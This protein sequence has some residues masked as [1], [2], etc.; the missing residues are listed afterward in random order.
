M[1]STR[2]LSQL[3]ASAERRAVILHLF[4]VPP[5]PDAEEH[6]TAGG[7]SSDATSL[8]VVMGS[9]SGSGHTQMPEATL[10]VVVTA[11]AIDNDTKRS[12]VCMYSFGSTGPPGHGLPP[13]RRD[14][15]V[16][17]EPDRLETPRCSRPAPSSAGPMP[18]SV[19][20]VPTP[21]RMSAPIAAAE[22]RQTCAGM[23]SQPLTA[24][25]DENTAL[26][27]S[28]SHSG[29][30]FIISSNAIRPSIRASALPR[31]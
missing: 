11:A 5:G 27:R 16:L 9:R 25:D 17:R 10:M 30:R 24:D 4:G 1:A 14:V 20:N 22:P 23:L 18:S 2:S 7:G 31:Q 26:S 28:T 15:G 3:P 13:G 8:A 29:K 6:A 19:T 12:W 21:K